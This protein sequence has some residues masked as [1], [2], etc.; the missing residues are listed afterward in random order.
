MSPHVDG[1][2]LVAEGPHLPASQNAH[3]GALGYV[4]GTPEDAGDDL[5]TTVHYYLRI[6][7]KRKWL[8]AGLTLLFVT[9]GGL[10]TLMKTPLYQAVARIQIDKKTVKVVEDGATTPVETDGNDFLRTQYELLQSRAMAERVVSA[11]HLESDPAFLEPRD[12]SLIGIVRKA[13]A[14]SREPAAPSPSGQFT[15]APS[16]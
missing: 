7:L 11:L 10:Y 12:V 2:D 8:I 13:I 15:M 6:V 4:V 9:I 5:A 3:G 14:G 16:I 1:R